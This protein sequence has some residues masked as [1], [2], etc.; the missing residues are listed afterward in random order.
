VVE[1]MGFLDELDG[2]M[3]IELI[4]YDAFASKPAPLVLM[5]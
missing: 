1:I 3:T 5:K 4:A 2:A